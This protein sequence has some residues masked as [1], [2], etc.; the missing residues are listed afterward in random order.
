[1]VTRQLDDPPLN[2]LAAAEAILVRSNRNWHTHRMGIEG[3]E[4][5]PQTLE[6]GMVPAYEPGF[7]VGADAYYLEDMV[8]ITDSG[9]RVLSANLQ[10]WASDIEEMMAR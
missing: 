2:G 5:L 10:Y 9:H 7:W 4:D 3:G 8:L 1:L 6:T